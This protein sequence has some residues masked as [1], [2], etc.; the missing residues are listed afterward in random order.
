MNKHY[1]EKIFS[2]ERMKKYFDR[3]PSDDEKAIKLYQANIAISEAFYPILAIFEVALRNSLNRELIDFFGTDDWYLKVDGYVGLKD[4]RNEINLAK[5]HITKRDETVTGSKVVAELTLGFWVRLLNAEYEKTLWKPLRKAFPHIDKKDKQ[6][7]KISAPINHIRGFRN[8][9]FHHE[10]IV[11]N[12]SSLE[13]THHDIVLVLSWIN[14]DLPNEII[15][16]D[17][18]L[19]TL[20][21]V[22]K[23]IYA[24]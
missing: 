1:Y 4:L 10:P 2:T 16:L 6:R 17:R 7:N 22:K 3:F 9:I 21:Q 15:E 23:E 14:K 19:K 11:W 12:L 20:E 8:R 18:V 13:R 24:N 5:K